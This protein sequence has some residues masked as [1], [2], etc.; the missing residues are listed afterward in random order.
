[1]APFSVA[2]TFPSDEKIEVILIRKW[3]NNEIFIYVN[4]FSACRRF[5]ETWAGVNI[6]VTTHVEITFSPTLLQSSFHEGRKVELR[7]FILCEFRTSRVGLV[8][9]F[10]H[11]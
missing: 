6:S 5:L 7:N 11:R 9:E 4:R 2:V 10:Q 3:T 8:L 1:M